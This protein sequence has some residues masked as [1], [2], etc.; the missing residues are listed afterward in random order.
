MWSSTCE[1]LHAI[2]F[3]P[4]SH[5][6]HQHEMWHGLRHA[7]RPEHGCPGHP[8]SSCA[9]I[10]YMQV[11]W[12]GAQQLPA[13]AA[14]PA[15]L[16]AQV[17]NLFVMPLSISLLAFL[18]GG[19]SG[20]CAL[21]A[22][23]ALAHGCLQACALPCKHLHCLASNGAHA[24]HVCLLCFPCLNVGRVLPDAPPTKEEVQHMS[25]AQLKAFL[26][27]KGAPP[28]LCAAPWI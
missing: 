25:V 24:L 1:R 16:A 7:E 3:V 14:R 12:Y 11:H 22:F 6:W 27:S 21:I 8:M 23:A 4:F 15:H 5:T 19:C 2:R 28:C 13:G 10:Q 20:M 9:L 18:C 17:S 26:Q